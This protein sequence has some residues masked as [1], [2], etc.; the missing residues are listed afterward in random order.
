MSKQDIAISIQN[1]YKSFGNE[2][3]L[4]DINHEFEEGKIHGIVGNNGSGKTVLFKCI[5]GFYIPARAR[6]LSTIN[7]WERIWIFLRTWE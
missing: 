5:C 1:V 4:R 7:R 6:Y 3:V 2:E